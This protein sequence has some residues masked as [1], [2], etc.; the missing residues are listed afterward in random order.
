MIKS[1][2]IITEEDLQKILTAPVK[3]HS[4]QTSKINTLIVLLSESGARVSE[5]VSLQVKDFDHEEK[6]LTFRSTKNGED[7][8]IPITEKTTKCLVKLTH[9]YPQNRFI[10][11][12][13]RGHM[14]RQSV[15]RALKLRLVR[16]GIDKEISPHTFRHVFITTKLREGKALPGIQKFVGHR[17]LQTT[18]KY[19]HFTM[20]DLREVLK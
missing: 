7:R 19:I 17:S 16:A 10:F 4:S 11:H 6:L 2:P 9:G 5:A 15:Y 8:K 13:H 12:T 3:S 1:Q 14:S 18:S 20:D